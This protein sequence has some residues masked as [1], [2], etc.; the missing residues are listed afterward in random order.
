MKNSQKK[1]LNP[2]SFNFP[3]LT[4]FFLTQWRP[5]PLPPSCKSGLHTAR[6]GAGIW[7]AGHE[8]GLHAARVGCRWCQFKGGGNMALYEHQLLKKALMSFKRPCELQ[9]ID[10]IPPKIILCFF[11]FFV[12]LNLWIL[13]PKTTIYDFV[14]VHLKIWFCKVCY[15]SWYMD[16]KFY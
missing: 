13:L 8:S 16:C 14:C 2:N 15:W 10:V 11:F 5:N 6:S 3:S 12:Y 1:N 4:F 9:S 7:V